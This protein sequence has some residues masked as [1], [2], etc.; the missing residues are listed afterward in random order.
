MVTQRTKKGVLK[1]TWQ[2][3]LSLII[4]KLVPKR[5]TTR[6]I[7]K[8]MEDEDVQYLTFES[9]MRKEILNEKEKKN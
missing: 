2:S 4:A 5:P 6:K 3:I 7:C 9:Y 1:A 8:D